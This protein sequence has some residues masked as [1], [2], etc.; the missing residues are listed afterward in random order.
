MKKNHGDEE[1]R[2][3]DPFM[4]FGSD[5]FMEAVKD[6]KEWH[7]S[8]RIFAKVID[9]YGDNFNELYDKY[10]AENKYVKVVKARELWFKF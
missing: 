5:K 2:A 10:V 7:L 4:D 6:N 3:R 1:Q 9:A 8:V